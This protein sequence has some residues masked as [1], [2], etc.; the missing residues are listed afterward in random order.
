MAK[1]I[2]RVERGAEP[3]RVPLVQR[4]VRRHLPASQAEAAQ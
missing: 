4:D 3:H 1:R 2:A